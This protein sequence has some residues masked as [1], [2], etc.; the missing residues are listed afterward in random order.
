MWEALA[1]FGTFFTVLTLIWVLHHR[2]ERRDFLA[3]FSHM[4]ER[5]QGYDGVTHPLHHV[6]EEVSKWL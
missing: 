2:A 1:V 6:M 5:Y 3:R 4:R